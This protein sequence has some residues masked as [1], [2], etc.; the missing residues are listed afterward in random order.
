VKAWCIPQADARFVAKMEDVLAV[1]QRPYN[2]A[3]PVICLD[4]SS[5]VLEAPTRP[6][7]AAAP[8]RAARQ[9]YTYQPQGYAS[10][11]M[12]TEPLRGWRR[13]AVT[14]Q[15]T[16]A[17]L[18]VQLA[19]LVEGDYPHA[20]RIVLVTDNLN[21]H[22]AG[23]LYAKYPPERARRIAA[24]LEWHYTPEHGSWL[25]IA[26][27]E[28]SIVK[29]Q[30]LA[31]RIGDAATLAAEVAAWQERQNA[32]AGQVEWQFTPEAARTKLLH[33]YPVVKT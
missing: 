25:N 18:A 27:L 2:P 30:C 20:E 12:L 29:R 28:W 19:Q 15:R 8:G 13:V 1:Y 22:H 24:R 7:Q 31:R 17:D 6:G 10:L 14:A 32:G 21:T 16:G 3:Q 33:L 23:V 26:E 11:F 5:K 4:E 9:D